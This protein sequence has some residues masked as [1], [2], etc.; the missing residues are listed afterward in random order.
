M[1]YSRWATEKELKSKLTQISYDS[2]IKKSGI[3]LMYDDKHLYIKDDEAHTI[4]IGSAGSGKTQITMLTQLRLAIKANE[5]FVIH[6]VKGEVYNLLSGELKKQN[7]NTVVINLDNP[8]LGNNFNPLTLPYELY[9]KGETDKAIELLENIG[10]YFC[11][12]ETFDA[13]TDPF[14]INSTTS[15]FIGLS[16]YL[17]EN[18][19]EEEI[20]ISS[21]LHLVSEFE[22]LSEK[23]KKMDKTS[24][25]YINLS[26]IVLATSKPV[27]FL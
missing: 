5:S 16:L 8:T 10:Y 20:N 7:Y 12:N 3:P 18:A 24:V 13:K 27:I 2:E 26:N 17:F 23:I 6:D 11:C 22:K 21:L 19:T 1:A 14:W 15:L 9:K 25:T 4:I